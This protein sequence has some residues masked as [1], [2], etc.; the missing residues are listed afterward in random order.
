[1]N[2]K[3]G[4]CGFKFHESIQN[5][6]TWYLWICSFNSDP[7]FSS[8]SL[9]AFFVNLIFLLFLYSVLKKWRKDKTLCTEKQYPWNYR[10]SPLKK[11]AYESL[12]NSVFSFK[13]I[14]KNLLHVNYGKS[15][16]SRIYLLWCLISFNYEG[17]LTNTKDFNS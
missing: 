15:C 1:M 6:L 14:K 13:K 11:N 17:N 5:Y 2:E 7:R 16:I 10:Q 8:L 4:N 3:N 9:S 12:I